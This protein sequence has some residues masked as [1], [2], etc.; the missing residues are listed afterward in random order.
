MFNKKIF[1]HK[2]KRHVLPSPGLQ[3]MNIYSEPASRLGCFQD[4]CDN[5]DDNSSGFMHGS[6]AS[7]EKYLECLIKQTP[8]QQAHDFKDSLPQPTTLPISYS[9]MPEAQVQEYHTF[10]KPLDPVSRIYYSIKQ[11]EIIKEAKSASLNVACSSFKPT[12]IPTL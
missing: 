9:Y 5:Q 4:I 2:E 6:A 10:F 11:K 12:F 8:Y 1:R 3:Y 7:Y